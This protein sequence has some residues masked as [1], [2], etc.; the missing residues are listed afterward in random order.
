MLLRR[1]RGITQSLGV[2]GEVVK[3]EPSSY[4]YSAFSGCSPEGYIRFGDPDRSFG[5]WAARFRE[6]APF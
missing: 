4:A 2:A 1:P 6:L 5:P 3:D